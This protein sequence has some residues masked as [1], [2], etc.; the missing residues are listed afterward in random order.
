[1]KQIHKAAGVTVILLIL[2][3]PVLYSC[4]AAPP[5]SGTAPDME[6]LSEPAGEPERRNS[7]PEE[8]DKTGEGDAGDYAESRP[9]SRI[10]DELVV[11][12]SLEELELDFRIS[13]YASEAQ[14]FTAIYEGLFSYHPLSMAPVP[15]AA[16]EYEISDDKKTW[17]F[18]IRDNARYQNGDP[19]RAADFKAAWLSL[20]EPEREAPYSSLFDIIE[21]AR[22]YRLGN[23][24]AEEVGISAP[25][26][27]TLIVRLNSPA[28]F[29]P[30]MLCHHSFSPIHPSMLQENNWTKPVSNG[31][32]YIE[33]IDNEHIL[34]IKNANY[35]DAR[36]V[37]LNKLTIKFPQDGDE[38]TAM[39]N[40][41]EARWIHGDMNLSTL[42]DRSGIEVNAMFA[43]YYYYICSARKPWDDYRLRHALTLVLPWEKIREGYS[44]PARTLIFPIPDYPDVDGLDTTNEEEARRLL[45]D[46]GYPGGVGLPELVIRITPAHDA[47]RLA[48]IMAEAWSGV[49]G[50]PVKIDVVPYRD[51]FQSLKGNDYDVGSTSWIGDFA[52]PYTFLQMWRRDSNLNDARHNDDD[53]EALIER[54]MTEEGTKRWETLAEAEELLLSRG[55]VMPIS[56][57]PAVNVI[58][59]NEI[60]GWY[61]NVLDIHPFKYMFIKA[62]RPLSGV[63]MVQ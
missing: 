43:T 6:V 13:Y 4:K 57:S 17:T 22:D 30:S 50:I 49:L 60:D 5:Y 20:L 62:L 7:P 14:I 44:L 61:P 25:D 28:A 38:A 10:R 26:D 32:F 15:A 42:T 16:S 56:Y 40:S 48:T 11:A 59:L 24:K 54:S 3:L 45:A 55:N 2:T 58:D 19:L 35:W 12:F 33:E 52:D 34:L 51:Y 63:A 8:M 31:P 9:R 18:K 39:W 46:A 37:S 53:Y 23:C 21:K 1:M 41:G 47:D 29:F 36:R 27:K